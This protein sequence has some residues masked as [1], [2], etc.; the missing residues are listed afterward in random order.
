MKPILI[1]WVW[2]G[3]LVIL[4]V[5]FSAIILESVL[6]SIV[7]KKMPLHLGI[8]AAC[9]IYTAITWAFYYNYATPLSAVLPWVGLV[10]LGGMGLK[11]VAHG[12]AKKG[13]FNAHAIVDFFKPI[14]GFFILF[15]IFAALYS[16]LLAD[17]RLP[18]VI[19]GN[20]DI[21]ACAKFT[22]LALNQPIGNNF[23]NLDLLKSFPG[24]SDQTPTTFMFLASLAYF[25]GQEVV[26]I[27]SVGLILVL[28][29]SAIIIKELCIKHWN[30]RAPLAYLIAIAWITSSVSFYLASNYFLP[31]W[32]GICLFLAT[33]LIALR[34]EDKILIQTATLSLLNYL[35]FMTYPA[36]FFPYMVILLFL[37]V[38]EAAF[39]WRNSG[40]VFFN[41]RLASIIF[42]IPV[43]LGIA[44]VLDIGH[45]KTM[46]SRMVALS[47]ANV[48]WPL[49][50]LNPFALM[51]FPFKQIDSG[52]MI[53]KVVGYF[54][55]L[56]LVCY[57]TYRAH[58]TKT[59]S[60]ARFALSVLFTS[61]LSMYLC[62]YALKGVSYQQWKFA[63]S[64][65][66]PL[67]FLPIVAV[68]S[69]F[70][71]EGRVSATVKHAL[72]IALIATNVFVMNKL[73]VNSR[74]ALSRYAPLRELTHYDQAP[75]LKAINVDLKDDFTGTMIAAQFVN[76][77]PLTL[78][79]RSYYSEDRA[80]DYSKL[81]PDNILVTN[82]CSVFD[83]RNLTMLGESFCILHGAPSLGE[84]FSIKFNNPLPS[85]LRTA[86]LSAQ[87]S[88]GRWS[89][90][91]KV[92]LDIPVNMEW[93][94]VELKI[95]GFP[96]ISSGIKRQGMSFWVHGSKVKELSV[97]SESEIVIYLNR[98]MFNDG[99]VELTIDLPDAVSPSKFGSPDTRVLG[100]G[101]YALEVKAVV[102]MDIREHE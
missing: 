83:S 43:S 30:V 56:A 86:G 88:W 23:V 3:L 13:I 57:L 17:R 73:T 42:S 32:L 35:M 71:G 81:S 6:A 2:E 64:I 54:T 92:V 1:D 68:V 60:S 69:A 98:A 74:S 96:F 25:S 31:Q 75:N 89:D 18:V 85:I 10:V 95:K 33:I 48:G 9:A 97:V 94:G 66:L 99:R 36:L 47:S 45:F 91:H 26:D 90:G 38:M 16:A 4:L 27:L 28:T 52:V 62:Y 39:S 46:I 34:N 70:D 41:P 50:L 11:L 7:R 67:S 44:C 40:D 55:I 101:F 84:E 53:P 37:A 20:N 59:L 65:V 14:V 76:Q 5:Y 58:K 93:K 77:K 72:L 63:G 79:S 29:M 21:W 12:Q 49:S 100:F 24:A 8:V 15:I 78:W 102:E 61:G 51:A 22:H 19:S 82:S 80:E 87:E